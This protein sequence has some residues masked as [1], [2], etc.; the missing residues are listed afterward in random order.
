M[1]DF[2]K[3]TPEPE[4]MD[5]RLQ[6]EAYAAADFS[7]PHQHCV[8][9]CAQRL[10][11]LTGKVLDLG[12]GP[13]DVLSRYAKANLTAQFVGVD[14]ASVM[15][16]LAKAVME[17]L[18]LSQRV[19]LEQHYLPSSALSGRYFDAVV[20]NSLLHHLNDPQV[21]WKTIET[22]GRSGAR[23]F[24]MDLMRPATKAQLEALVHKYASDA[25]PVLFRDFRASLHAAYRLDEVKAQL[26]TAGLD[27]KVEAVS[28]RHLIAWGTLP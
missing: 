28:D 2:L 23:V 24:V 12:C 15:L 16:A 20:S 5:E 18:G 25:P 3:R 27:L 9:T 7:E 10:G 22:S 26:A 4:L 21:L 6:A 1:S 11:E 17:E 8:N 14:G 13:G 19:A